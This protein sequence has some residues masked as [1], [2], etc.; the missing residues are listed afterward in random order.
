MAFTFRGIDAIF[1]FVLGSRVGF[2]SKCHDDS[3]PG[4]NEREKRLQPIKNLP[5]AS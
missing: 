2:F 3:E 1:L 5:A 4:T